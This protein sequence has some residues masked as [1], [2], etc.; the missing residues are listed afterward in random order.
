[1]LKFL[2]G[3]AVGVVLAVLSVR[4]DIAPPAIFGL[5]DKVRANLVSTAIEG[6]L[7][8][9][10]AEAAVRERALE[11]YFKNRAG[12]AAALDAGAGHPFL[13]ALL[14]ARAAR[15]AQE[16]IGQWTAYDA[17]LAKPALRGVLEK[18]HGTDVAEALKRAMLFDALERKPF[19]KSW[20]AV[21]AGEVT[22]ENLR[23]LLVATAK[24]TNVKPQPAL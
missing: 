5:P 20:L 6:D 22:R 24:T 1:M 9:L 19:L 15:E 4:F 11:V 12:D 13:N 17:V 18:K 7:Y 8:D 10:S 21:Y 2:T 14:R 16:L 23:A 3:T